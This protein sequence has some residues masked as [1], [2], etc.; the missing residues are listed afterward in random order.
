M[1]LA[2]TARLLLASLLTAAAPTSPAVA[3]PTTDRATA[4]PEVVVSPGTVPA[5][6]PDAAPATSVPAPAA[7][8][9]PGTALPATP[10]RPTPSATPPLR[11]LLIMP[12]VGIQGVSSFHVDA[13]FGTGVRLGGLAG[14]RITRWLSLNGAL[15]V[16]LG[17]T[18]MAKQGNQGTLTEGQ[19]TF[20]PLVHVGNLR[21][22]DWRPI[23]AGPKI[24]LLR[25]SGYGNFGDHHDWDGLTYG[26]QLGGF[27]H[28]QRV[29]PGL[30]LSLDYVRPFSRTCSCNGLHDGGTY[31]PR[32][33]LGS[34]MLAV[35][36]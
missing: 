31:P 27:I 7:P 6:R 12:F 24:G 9:P 2:P 23:L 30:M 22:N 29:S 10:D 33:Y 11:R 20:S 17:N 5:P 15:A 16:D 14:E 36:F 19:L 8:A 32:Y 28:L 3:A 13:D 1:L 4:E 18:S 21:P 34:A 26:G 35:I 25:G